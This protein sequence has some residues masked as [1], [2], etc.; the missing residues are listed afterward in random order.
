MVWA[1]MEGS[2]VDLPTTSVRCSPLVLRGFISPR[3]LISA[4]VA[5]FHPVN[6]YLLGQQYL[7]LI[8][9]N[10]AS[11]KVVLPGKCGSGPGLEGWG[12]AGWDVKP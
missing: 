7:G 5:S 4:F 6:T 1:K 2:G 11:F 10:I 3:N 8:L 12:G 9:K